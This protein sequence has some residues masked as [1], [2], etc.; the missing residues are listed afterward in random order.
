M[1]KSFRPICETVR[2]HPHVLAG[3][4]GRRQSGRRAHG[5]QYPYGNYPWYSTW[6]VDQGPFRVQEA[7]GRWTTR[8][9]PVAVVLPPYSGNR[10][11]L[12]SSTLY[13][14]VEWGAVA[15][16]RIPRQDGGPAMRYP[17]GKEQPGP[18]KVWGAPLP[19]FVGP[20]LLETTRTLL[21]RVNT[22]WWRAGAFRLRADAELGVWI[23]RLLCAEAAGAAGVESASEGEDIRVLRD[24]LDQGIGV[25][26]WA[27][28]LGIHPRT[29]H[30][31]C[32]DHHH[33]T[34]HEVMNRVRLEVAESLLLDPGRDIPD[35]AKRCGFS[36]REAF[37]AWFARQTGHPPG[38][39]R[40]RL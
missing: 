22:L 20:D 30:R 8:Q 35:A 3:A 32:R 37:S 27:G 18:E 5:R 1:P 25:G 29:L 16:R 34:P 9:G 23:S 6:M 21:L 19:L 24:A 28:L 10:I 39:W 7:G 12:P 15:M 2:Y 11:D 31:R 4:V 33:A 14:W 40:Q 17:P 38:R 36:T 26:D 13:S